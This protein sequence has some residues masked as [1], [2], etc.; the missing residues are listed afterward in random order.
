MNTFTID[1]PDPNINFFKLGFGDAHLFSFGGGIV[2][3]QKLNKHFSLQSE[4]IYNPV[5]AGLG[6]VEYYTDPHGDIYSAVNDFQ[7][8]LH[9]LEIPLLAKIS[10]GNKVTF[11]VLGG[12]YVDYLL[13][14]KQSTSDGKL[15]V[16]DYNSQ[17]FEEKQINYPKQ[18]VRQDYTS[19]NGGLSAGFSISVNNRMT[20][21]F[22]LNKGMVNINKT[23]SAKMYTLQGQF[24]VGWYMFRYKKKK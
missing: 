24:G 17:T 4:L 6:K 15:N 8:Q 13:L 10:F 2:I 18:N 23:G 7:I 20:F 14:A 22:R 3:Y 12:M 5:N 9:Y 16:V 19:F 21:E 1:N 11:D